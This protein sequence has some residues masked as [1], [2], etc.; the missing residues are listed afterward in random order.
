MQRHLANAILKAAEAAK[1]GGYLRLCVCV[2]VSPCLADDLSALWCTFFVA[3]A[4]AA[5]TRAAP[6]NLIK[7]YA[8]LPLH[9]L[10]GERYQVVGKG[11]VP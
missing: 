4:A 2:C 11:G 6:D 1:R 9:W 7:L 10:Q 5:R 3:D 8:S